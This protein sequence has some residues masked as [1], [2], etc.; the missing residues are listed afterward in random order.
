M[1]DTWA[2]NA[3]NQLITFKAFL[4][5]LATGGFYGFYYPSAPPDTREI[6]TVGDLNTYGIYFYSYFGSAY[7]YDTF[8][9]VSNSKCLT[10]L[11]LILQAGFDI[12][13]TNITSCSAGSIENQVLYSTSFAVGAQLYSNRA[14]TT[15][16][17]FATSRW[18]YNFSFGGAS[19]QVNTSGVILSIVSC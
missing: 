4:D 15:A 11:D 7:L 2:G 16:K 6:M 13:S 8:T 19:Y 3:N 18:L 10:K 1:A 12:S 9:G 5:G 17:T 14:L